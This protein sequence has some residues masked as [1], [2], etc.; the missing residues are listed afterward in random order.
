MNVCPHVR[1]LA[2]MLQVVSHP[3]PGQSEPAFF[4]VV[5]RETG[6]GSEFGIHGV[7]IADV[8]VLVRVT[9][10][11]IVAALSGGND[12]V[13]VAQ[14][15]LDIL[16][17]PRGGHIGLG[18]LLARRVD[19]NRGQF[20]AGLAERPGNPDRRVTRRRADLECA[21]EFV[22]DDEV[23][24]DLSVFVWHIQIAPSAAALLQER[25]DPH[26]QLRIGNARSGTYNGEEQT[27]HRDRFN[28]G[29]Q[30]PKAFV[31]VIPYHKVCLHI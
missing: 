30:A 26:I 25:F 24:K 27:G 15:K 18:L 5:G 31:R 4:D 12:F 10:D 6:V 8:P 7:E 29:P 20:T 1:H 21:G 11:E 14:D 23:V 22:F 9:E 16:R 2:N 17:Q 19:L 28:N 3:S 13:C